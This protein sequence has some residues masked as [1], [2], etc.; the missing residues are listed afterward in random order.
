MKEKECI[1]SAYSDYLPR[2]N[3]GRGECVESADLPYSLYVRF[4]LALMAKKQPR[5][6]PEKQ[7]LF[8][9]YHSISEKQHGL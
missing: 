3:G 5:S 7:E 9:T 8:E 6:S 2:R 1:E 4:Q